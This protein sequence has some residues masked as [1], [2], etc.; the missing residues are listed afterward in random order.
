MVYFQTKNP[1]LGNFWRVLQLMMLV[2]FMA[3]RTILLP[4][5]I[6]YGHL[7]HFVVIWNIFPV[8]VYCTK[9]NLA[10]QALRRRFEHK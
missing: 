7:V 8:L 10:T 3:I 1:N 6:F 5:G 4:L 9:K 2:H